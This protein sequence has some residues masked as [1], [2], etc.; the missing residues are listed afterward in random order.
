MEN[1]DQLL[2][3]QKFEQALDMCHYVL[4]PYASGDPSDQTR[5]WQFP[6][7]KEIDAKQVLEKLFFDLQPGQPTDQ[8]NAWRNKP[9]QPHLV[10]RSRPA[11]YMKYVAMKYIEILI[12]WGDYLFRQDTI[13]AINQATQLYVLA[14]H[15][16]GPRGQKIPKRGKVKAA[17]Y[18]S[19]LDKWDDL[20]LHGGTSYK[21]KL[22]T[23]TFGAQ[24]Q[25]ERHS[26]KQR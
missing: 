19:L 2:K 26:H 20:R 1:V 5:F 7:F 3:V 12:A 6:P 25:D 18:M 22:Y 13:E 8:I 16:Y 4:N 17:T 23:Q 9:F 10:A 11:A 14:A 15:I 21:R 24:I